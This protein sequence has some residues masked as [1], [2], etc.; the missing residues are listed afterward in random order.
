M[1][2]VCVIC[3]EPRWAGLL[4]RACAD[5]ECEVHGRDLP[6]LCHGERACESCHD[7]HGCPHVDE[8]CVDCGKSLDCG[9]MRHPVDGITAKESGRCAGCAMATVGG[10]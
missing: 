6:L 7:A 8:E 1:N 4:C 2:G 9:T 10:A 3:S 5:Y